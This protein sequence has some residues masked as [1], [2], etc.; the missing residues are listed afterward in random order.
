[1]S[2]TF[3]IYPGGAVGGDRGVVEPA[4]ADDPVLINR[5]LD[6]LQGSADS[7]LVRAYLPFRP[8]ADSG[9]R[10]SPAEPERLL[11]PTGAR[12]EASRA[13]RLELVLGFRDPAG[14]VEAWLA[15]V[16][17][18]VTAY[19][20]RIALLQICEEPTVDQPCLDGATPNVLSALVRGVVTA[21]DQAR[22]LGLTDLAIGFNATPDLGA[23]LTF[24]HDLAAVAAEEAPDFHE[25][26]GYV[27]FDFFPDVFRP[28]PEPGLARAV[29]VVLT[30]FRERVLPAAG[31]GPAVPIHIAE[32]GWS[33]GAGRAEQRQAEV[34]QTVLS[35]ILGLGQRLNITGYSHFCLR[36]A[37][38]AAQ[39]SLYYGFG[40]LHT[41]YTPKPAF[42]VYQAAIARARP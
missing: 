26:L 38:S 12:T 22:A 7:F 30:D 39:D 14:D 16:R 5:A 21:R 24:W 41:D 10:P 15:F 17:E 31:I 32:N 33:T 42:A 28:I 35:T 27:G 13:R 20:D 34:L 1:M 19:G 4:A 29:E 18:A 23:D 6:E 25:A 3:G 11:G 9:E 36:D 8:P 40:L 2:F 37:D